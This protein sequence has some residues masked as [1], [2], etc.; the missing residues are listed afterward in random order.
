[1][2]NNLKHIM[3]LG[4]FMLSS[5]PTLEALAEGNSKPIDEDKKYAWSSNAGWLNF[6][7]Q[8]SLVETVKIYPDHLEGYVW[9]E[10]IGWIKLGSYSGGEEHT[11]KNTELDNWGVNNDGSGNLS[12]YAWSSNVGWINFAPQCSDC[13]AVTINSTTGNFE[14][15]AWSENV[16]WINFQSVYGV[17]SPTNPFQ[18][19]VPQ[20]GAGGDDSR[21]LPWPNPR[22]TINDNGTVTDNQTGLIWLRDASCSD[23]EGT[24]GKATWEA[25]KTAVQA[26]ANGTCGLNDNSAA[27]DWYLPSVRELHSLIHFGVQQPALPN[28][29]GTGQWTNNNP[30]K[31]VKSEQYWSITP[32]IDDDNAAWYVNIGNGQVGITGKTQSRYVWPVRGG[33]PE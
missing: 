4:S 27:G 2:N 5:L 3:L 29:A 21:G 12:G 22:F 23:L 20:T 14:G 11:Y 13:P 7:P 25:A 16:E 9:G 10:N 31:E 24:E 30:F 15:Y 33:V 18:A 8:L 26:L 6:R 28:T 17:K 32:K 19:Q 1:M